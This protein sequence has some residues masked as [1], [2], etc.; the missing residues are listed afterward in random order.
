MEKSFKCENCNK[1]ISTMAV[2]T[3]NRNHC[4]HC[5]WSK[6]V[7][8]DI[9][10]RQ[11]NCKGLMKPIGL[12]NKKDGEI[13]LIHQCVK[14]GKIS[15]NRIAGDDEVEIIEKVFKSQDTQKIIE[16]KLIPFIDESELKLQLHGKKF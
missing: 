5:L 16:S 1:T 3:K 14:C 12:T 4:P 10:D 11:A 15:T 8:K 6:H 13:M 2:G 9:G 7:D